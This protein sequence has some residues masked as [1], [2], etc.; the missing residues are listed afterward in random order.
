MKLQVTLLLLGILSVSH[1]QQKFMVKSVEGKNWKSQYYLVDAK[2]NTVKKLDSTRYDMCFSNF[3]KA[4]YFAIFGIRGEK[5]WAAVDIN[6]RILFKLY[7]T[8][9]GEPS[10]DEIKEGKIRI[11]DGAGKIGFANYL[12]NIIIK[13][14][15]EIA[16]A[17][18]HGKAIIGESCKKV[19]W[20]KHEE[21][22]SDPHYS[23]ICQ[24]HGYINKN[25]EVQLLGSFSY[26]DVKKRLNWKDSQE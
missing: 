5:G 9:I 12:G 25:G 22:N 13:P 15:F 23:I 16:T 24:K 14:Q 8:S 19:P 7:N 17:F 10:P 18:H 6:E 3:D 21:E 11:V 1:A 26:E 20:G 4:G 2:G